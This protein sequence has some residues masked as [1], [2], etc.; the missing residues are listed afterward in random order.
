MLVKKDIKAKFYFIGGINGVGKSTFLKNIISQKT[1]QEFVLIKG[2]S[3]FMKWLGLRSGDYNK[4]QKLNERFKNKELEK[5]ICFIIKT[6]QRKN[7]TF[8][9]D[10]HYFHYK[11]GIPINTIGKW[12]KY[13]TALFLIDAPTEVIL[14]R[15]YKDKNKKPEDRDLFPI[16][17][18]NTE[19][20]KDIIS[21]YRMVTVRKIKELSSKHKISYFIINNER[22][23]NNTIREF[24]DCHRLINK[25]KK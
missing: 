3:W 24:M 1:N 17:L 14:R 18:Y 19:K 12:I 13:F 23:I 7:K 25:I 5:M 9:F 16:N 6:N 4:L 8:L 2:I 21:M 11:R 22:N 15:I 10:G 20:Q